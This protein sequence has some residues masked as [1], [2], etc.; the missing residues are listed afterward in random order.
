MEKKEVTLSVKKQNEVTT[1][2]YCIQLI[3]ILITIHVNGK[4][5]IN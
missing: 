1:H 2:K 4:R 3:N 5:I